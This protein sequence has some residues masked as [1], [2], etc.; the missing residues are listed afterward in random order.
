MI[1][2]S[3]KKNWEIKFVKTNT[4]TVWPTTEIYIILSETFSTPVMLSKNVV[5][6]K[7]LKT[8]CEN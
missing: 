2:Y 8:I 5:T 1:K 6:N 7:S 3:Q 4:S